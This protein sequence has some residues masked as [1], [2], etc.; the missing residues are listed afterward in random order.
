MRKLLP[1]FLSLLGF[2]SLTFGQNSFVPPQVALNVVNGITRPIAGATITVCGPNASGIPCSPP[3]AGVI[4]KDA[5]GSQPLTNPFFSDTYGNYQFAAAAGIY[6]VTVTA[7]GYQGYSYQVSAGGGSGG[8]SP[9]NSVFGRI[10][11]ITAQ[12]GDYTCA[13]VTGCGSGGSLPTSWIY[14]P[15]GSSQV[16]IQTALNSAVSGSWVIFS[17]SYSACGLT[18]TTSGVTIDGLNRDGT[19]ISCNTASSPVLTVSGSFDRVMRLNAKHN[20]TPT[21]PGG[22]LTSTCGD[23]IQVLG[24]ASRVT[25]ENTHENFDYIG[26]DTGYTDWGEIANNITEFNQNHGIAFN[27]VAGHTVYQYQVHGNLSEQ[28]LGNGFDMTCPASLTSLQMTAP[29][30]LNG[31]NVAYG[32][33]YG[34]NFSCSAATTSGIADVFLA[35][36]FA[37]INN[38][39]GLR[40]DQGPNGGRNAIIGTFYSE[41]SGSFTGTAGYAQTAQSAT[42][43]GYG[44]E[45]TSSCDPTTAPNITGATLW[46]NSYSGALISCAGTYIVA[47]TRG[48]GTAGASAQTESG[49]TINAANVSFGGWAKSG[50]AQASGI[51]LLSGDTPH[52]VGFNSDFASAAKIVVGT[53]PTNGFQ[54]GIGNSQLF[55]GSGVPTMNCPVGALYDNTS[56]ISVATIWYGCYPANVWTQLGS[57]GSAPSVQNLSSSTTVGFAGALSTLINATTGSSSALILT[58]PTAA[59][60]TGQTIT[61]KKVDTG[62]AQLSINTTSSQTIDGTLFGTGYIISNF[63]QYVTVQS[64]G[65]N[66]FIVANN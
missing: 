59:G 57:A 34:Y 41:L 6:T 45:V 5:A 16:V 30:F 9:V 1:V 24:G 51:Y 31:G 60:I 64:D 12:S 4:F 53:A 28:N 49:I 37:S 35:G 19:V 8:S 38:N 22:P 47:D 3:L 55:T 42:N 23:G 32:N 10:G 63:M 54:Q 56:A 61:L 7:P 13:Q 25:I 46:A 29:Y 33:I 62:T 18:L 27:P 15:A 11:S 65:A 17:G 36:N 14:I 39:S 43:V 21:C 48:N 58:L 50:G 2:A 26:I 52:N 20:V 66:W 40:L 44:I